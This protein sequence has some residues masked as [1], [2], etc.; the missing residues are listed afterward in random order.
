MCV[1]A[2]V[3]VCLCVCVRCVYMCV[4]L[5]EYDERRLFSNARSN[6][7]NGCTWSP[8]CI[9][10]WQ[11]D[12]TSMQLGS[13]L[14]ALSRPRPSDCIFP[15]SF[16]PVLSPAG[17]PNIGMEKVCK[18]LIARTRHHDLFPTKCSASRVA[19]SKARKTRGNWE[20]AEPRC[21]MSPKHQGTERNTLKPLA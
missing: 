2:C 4:Q 13:S 1:C 10:P 14:Q 7:P 21:S 15:L 20:L 9:K 16:R 18:A 12:T 5:S 11:R 17:P 6:H 19:V 3:C 8:L